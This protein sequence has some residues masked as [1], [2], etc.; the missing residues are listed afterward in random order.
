MRLSFDLR[1]SKRLRE[2]RARVR[3]GAQFLAVGWVGDRLYSIIIA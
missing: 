2:N 3:G 1:K